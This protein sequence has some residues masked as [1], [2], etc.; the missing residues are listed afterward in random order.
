MMEMVVTNGAIRH[1][2]FQSKCHHQQI[3]TQLF[4]RRIPFLWPNQQLQST[5]GKDDKMNLSSAFR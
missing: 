1:A 4:T 2:K 3:S 5:K